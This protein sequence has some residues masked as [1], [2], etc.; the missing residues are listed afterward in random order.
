M[1]KLT[2]LVTKIL[3]V[4]ILISIILLTSLVSSTPNKTATASPP[5]QIDWDAIIESFWGEIGLTLQDYVFIG[6]KPGATDGYDLIDAPKPAPPMGNYV[7]SYFNRPSWPRTSTISDYRSEITEGTSKTWGTAPQDT[8][9]IR[10]TLDNGPSGVFDICGQ[11]VEYPIAASIYIRLNLD[12]EPGYN[13][14]PDDYQISLQYLGG[15]N[16]KPAG[17]K[18]AD[19][20]APTINQTWDLKTTSQIV[21]PLW[22]SDFSP[23]SSNCADNLAPDMAK[24]KII[25]TNPGTPPNITLNKSV[26]RQGEVLRGQ[27]LN[28]TITY[29]NSGNLDASFAKIE[30]IIPSGTTYIPGSASNGGT[31]DNVKIIWD[32]GTVLK[33]GGT[34]TVTFQVRVD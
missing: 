15:I 25:V 31:F 24:F 18:L 29:T 34:G 9:N 30:D 14:P 5:S 10:T 2:K 22:N 8:L 32:I 19:A 16:S 17:T 33:N 4:A 21:I 12:L 3:P 20:S 28:Y 26:D 13:I 1:N 27:T 23:L 11:N 7:W 6:V